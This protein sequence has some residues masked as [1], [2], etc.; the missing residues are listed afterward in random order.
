[1]LVLGLIA[2]IQL[3][4]LVMILAVVTGSTGNAHRSQSA[5]QDQVKQLEHLT[6]EA[7]LSEAQRAQQSNNHWAS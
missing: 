1:M 7:M 3:A 4:V 6:I 2:L 5:P